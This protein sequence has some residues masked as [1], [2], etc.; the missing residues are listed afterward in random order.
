M[1][2]FS[3]WTCVECGEPVVNREE[4]LD[5]LTDDGRCPT[6]KTEVSDGKEDK[7]A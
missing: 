4:A 2:D 3:Y 1:P 7:D 6:E 5:H